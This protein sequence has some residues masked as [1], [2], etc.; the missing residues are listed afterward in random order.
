MWD[1]V[2]IVRNAND[3]KLAL[4]TIRQLEK[5]VDST[6]ANVRSLELKNMVLVGKLITTAALARKESRGTHY[7]E[8]HPATDNK[9][10]L[11]HLYLKRE[12]GRVGVSFV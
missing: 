12:D 4:E 8:D 9:H 5:K 2:G 3:L 10:W 6:G 1:K 7:R 11:R